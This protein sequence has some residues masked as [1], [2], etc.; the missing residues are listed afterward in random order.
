[1]RKSTNAA[2]EDQPFES[3]VPALRISQ[4]FRGLRP[5]I[6]VIFQKPRQ[7]L[8]GSARAAQKRDIAMTQL[9]EMLDGRVASGFIVHQYGIDRG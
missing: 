5:L 3:S 9:V 2:Q 8:A 7:S 6:R 4:N 1:M